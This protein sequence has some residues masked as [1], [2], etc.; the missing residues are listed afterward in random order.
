[1]VC[2]KGKIVNSK[3]N[4]VLNYMN[5][6]TSKPRIR[7]TVFM[8]PSLGLNGSSQSLNCK[9]TETSLSQHWGGGGCIANIFMLWAKYR[10][11]LCLLI[12][13][14]RYCDNMTHCDNSVFS[15]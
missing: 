7:K 8:S 6:C 10:Y 12:L 11:I 2:H 3:T 9:I 13:Y 4:F 14:V 5:D 1:M 15:K